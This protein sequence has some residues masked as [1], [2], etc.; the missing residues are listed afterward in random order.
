MIRFIN[1]L[2]TITLLITLKLSENTTS[3][4]KTNVDFFLAA[5]VLNTVKLLSHKKL[6]YLLGVARVPESRE[7][8]KYGRESRGT[9]NQEWR[10]Q[11]QFTRTTNKTSIIALNLITR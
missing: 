4:T 5:A 6:H 2:V 11:Q 1:S 9:W 10:S 8:V 7:I 3:Y